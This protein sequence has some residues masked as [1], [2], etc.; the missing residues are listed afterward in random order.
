MRHTSLYKPLSLA[1]FLTLLACQGG[2]TSTSP[3]GNPAAMAGA[4]V[5]AGMGMIKGRVQVDGISAGA[6]YRLSQAAS[7]SGGTVTARGDLDTKEV[8][9][10]ADGTF[11]VVV[12]GGGTYTLEATVP[13]GRGGVTRVVSPPISVPLAQDPPI[14]D[15][16]SLVTRR[17]GSIQGLIELKDAKEGETPEGV[18]VFLSGGTS[19]VGKAGETGRFA[20]TNVAEGTWNVVV[21]KPGY[22]RQV[23][24][25]VVV[26]AGRPSLLDATVVLEREA[27]QQQ[28]G[29]KGSVQSS[30]GRAIIGATVSLYPKDRKT[31]AA[32][33]ENLDNFTAIT[34]EEGRY[35][36]SNLPPGDYT[37]QVYR[38]FY[39]VPPRRSITV[40]TGAPQDL[41]ATKLTSTTIY[42]CRLSGT[43]KD[44]NGKPIDGAVVQLEPPVTEAQ[45]ADAGG[46][47]TLDRILP[48]EYQLSIA[49]GGYVPVII[50]VLIDNKPNCAISLPAGVTLGEEGSLN[51]ITPPV[52]PIDTEPS[53]TP[54]PVIITPAPVPATPVPTPTPEP[55]PTPAPEATTAP[56]PAPTPTPTPTPVPTPVVE[57]FKVETLAGSVSGHLD[58]IGDAA[59]FK[60]PSGIAVDASGTIYVSDEGNNRIRKIDA[61]LAVTT[62]A[63]SF[64]GSKDGKGTSAWLQG[65]VGI[66]VDAARNLFV[67]DW[68]NN[69]IRKVSAFAD[70]TTLAGESSGYVDNVGRLARFRAPNGVAVDASGNLFVADSDNHR[71]RKVSPDGTVTT[72]AGAGPGYKDGVG[73]AAQFT[74]PAGLAFDAAGFL[75]V[76][77]SGNQIIRRISSAGEVSTFAGQLGA[78][79]HVDAAVRTGARF[80]RPVSVV[81]RNDGAVFVADNSN[82]CIRKITPDGKVLTVAGSTLGFADGLGTAARFNL[83]QG[84]AIDA[85]GNLFVADRGNHRIR[86][87]SLQP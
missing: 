2:P 78:A 14:V 60:S 86:K 10:G 23:I 72:F 55:R 70:V 33:E 48:G 16:A 24:K 79:G 42:F 68:R 77:D 34:D 59:R 15:A 37:L 19:V 36:V 21:A 20:L 80:N 4:A 56:T 9:V 54:P 61:D 75:Y 31:S 84:L 12:P 5:P 53:P 26:R 58:G 22:K 74:A 73:S 65:P 83:P 49:A 41:G 1:L 38:P 47:F 46:N 66:V 11:A 32:A 6:G 17:T 81:V 44:A 64:P 40:A 13:D 67:A 29:V 7:A 43:V 82:H 35:E 63:G 3:Q 25:G 76:A 52:I 50:P 71:I 45:F 39:Q 85:A 57:V 28:A 87:V 62:F 51:P 30:D 27:Q 8:P 69:R 18:D